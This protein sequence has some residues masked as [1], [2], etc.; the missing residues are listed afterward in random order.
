VYKPERAASGITQREIWLNS[1]TGT[2][3][4]NRA[5]AV[6]EYAK[7]KK[8]TL[9]VICEAQQAQGLLYGRDYFLSD[10]VSVETIAGVVKVQVKT[11]TLSIT[12]DGAE[13][14]GI[15]LESEFGGTTA[16]RG[17]IFEPR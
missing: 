13:T 8:E 11:V 15:T 9:K 10:L 6:A 3:N 7:M 14:I 1:A 5:T 17:G 16:A 12:S 4:G 2:I